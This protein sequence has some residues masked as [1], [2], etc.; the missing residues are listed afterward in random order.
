[1]KALE[2]INSRRPNLELRGSFLQQLSQWERRTRHLYPK[3]TD[4]WEDLLLEKEH[5]PEAKN[6]LNKGYEYQ[7]ELL[8]RNTFMNAQVQSANFSTNWNSED[9]GNPKNANQQ[10]K[11][12]WPDNPTEKG[13]TDQVSDPEALAKSSSADDLL[14]KTEVN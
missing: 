3:R 14:N 5:D 4:R 2:F 6:T 11:V 13:A 7:D 10:P 8:L 12:R 1:M 9:E